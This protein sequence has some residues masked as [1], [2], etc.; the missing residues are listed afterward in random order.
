M[1]AGDTHSGKCHGDSEAAGGGRSP[2][3]GP[4]VRGAVGCRCSHLSRSAARVSRNQ[5]DF[6]NSIF[7]QGQWKS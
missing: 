3:L 4:T 1:E 2:A 7:L 6:H 5:E